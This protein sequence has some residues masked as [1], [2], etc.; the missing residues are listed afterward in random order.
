ETLARRMW[1][2]AGLMSKAGHAIWN[3]DDPAAGHANT[4]GMVWG[5]RRPTTPTPGTPTGDGLTD[6]EPKRP[7]ADAGRIRRA[8]M[9]Q[10]LRWER[11]QDPFRLQTGATGRELDDIIRGDPWGDSIQS[12][13][14][15]PGE[16]DALIAGI[17]PD[18]ILAGI[19]DIIPDYEIRTQ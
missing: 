3:A 7:E 14:P 1:D 4:L 12:L 18:E 13:M 10:E 5:Q 11:G 19:K 6:A 17:E 8:M 9:Q 16:I 2:A 15:K